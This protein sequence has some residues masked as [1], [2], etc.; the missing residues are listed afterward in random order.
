MSI[1]PAGSPRTPSTPWRL[2][3]VPTLRQDA[4]GG[5]T[6][7]NPAALAALGATL[8][9]L[10]GQQVARL[11]GGPQSPSHED[12]D[13]L[14]RSRGGAE[15]QR[16]FARMGQGEAAL[17]ILV[18][19]TLLDPNDPQQSD[20]LTAWTDVSDLYEAQ[21]AMAQ[22]RDDALQASMSK[23][24]FMANISHEL[25]TPL[26]S[27][28]GFSELGQRRARNDEA[29]K[30]MFADVQGAGQR[31]LRLVNDL[32]DLARSD[33]A[34]MAMTYE[35]M[36]LRGLL[37]EVVRETR[38]LAEAKAVEVHVQLPPQP[39]LAGVDPSRFQ[40]VLRNVIANAIKFSPQGSAIDIE[41][42]TDDVSG[43]WFT[44]ADRGP[45]IPALEIEKI[46]DAFFQSSRTKDGSGGTGLGLAISRR[47]MQAHGGRIEAQAREGGGAVF[48][49]WMPDGRVA[50]Q[51]E[52]DLILDITQPFLGSLKAEDL[53]PRGPA[54]GTRPL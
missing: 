30:G 5:V 3:G 16:Y 18:I 39:L 34:E 19:K 46:F 38:L 50:S 36:D 54:S 20:I 23:N 44:V 1:S 31:M 33:L 32:L 4:A 10:Q 43:I 52:D 26:Q 45:G 51:D 2:S 27:I 35:F 9:D 6:D 8:E 24:E 11:L 7:A 48:R 47:I 37:R 41:G 22:A 28:I 40:Q 29:L 21:R 13:A 25:R 49:L 53:D 12:Q 42:A 14:L 15:A 17:D